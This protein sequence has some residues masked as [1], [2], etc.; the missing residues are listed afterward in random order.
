MYNYIPNS[1]CTFCVRSC[2]L[3]CVGGDMGMVLTAAS[4]STCMHTPLQ[5]HTAEKVKRQ[6]EQYT[7]TEF[8]IHLATLRMQN[9]GNADRLSVSHLSVSHTLLIISTACLPAQLILD[10][11]YIILCSKSENTKRRLCTSCLTLAHLACCTAH[12]TPIGLPTIDSG[13]FRPG[14]GHCKSTELQLS[15]DLIIIPT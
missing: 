8:K 1:T 4:I 12:L 6:L 13:N 14:F 7:C 11:I 10:I 3:V 5:V 2:V 15:L 9:F